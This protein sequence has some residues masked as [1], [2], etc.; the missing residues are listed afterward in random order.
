M[1]SVVFLAAA[2]LA[3]GC[4]RSPSTST[5]SPSADQEPQ[6]SAESPA[7]FKPV[8]P[9]G[10]LR[11]KEPPDQA[12]KET[13][14]I[15]L[16]IPHPLPSAIPLTSGVPF[17]RGVATS[18]SHLRLED[19][20]GREIPIQVAGLARWPDGSYKSIAITM[21]AEASAGPQV[22]TLTSGPAATRTTSPMPALAVSDDADRVTIT[23]GPMRLQI[24]K[25]PFH[26][27]EQVWTD[28]N[29]DHVFDDA[30]RLLREPA[31]IV[32]I[33]AKDGAE[34][35]SA[36]ESKPEVVVE[37][38]GPVRAVVRS[39]GWL[40]ADGGKPLTKFIVRTTAYAGRDWVEV[41]YTL[42]DPREERINAPRQGLALE[43]TGYGIRVPTTIAEGTGL[44]AGEGGQAYRGPAAGEHFLYQR[45]TLNHV[46]G[47]FESYSF[48]FEG[49]ARG[50]RADGWADL[51]NA[52]A[53]AAVVL[54][55]FWQ[56][57]PKELSVQ[58]QDLTIWLHPPRAAT[59][60]PD[61][62]PAN[63]GTRYERPTTFYA[64]REG[65]AKT[66]QLLFAFHA[67]AGDPTQ[68]RNLAAAFQAHP[69]LI[70]SAA[71]YC[72][73]GAF[74]RLLEAGAWS[75]GY[76]THLIE[77]IY[78]PSIGRKREQ[79]GTAMQYGWRDFGDRM[80][81]GWAGE[82]NG[83]K[84]PGFYNDTHVGAHIFLIQY[85][86]TLDPRWWETGET[87]TRHWM[88]L[89]VSH[90]NRIGYWKRNGR[91]VGFGPGEGHLI[92]HEMEDHHS[93][94]LHTGHAHV[95]GL[96]D[97]Y[98]LTGD[99]R[100]LEVM[101]EVGDWW[102]H[103]APVLFP[104]P[105]PTP[106]GA[107]AERD[108]GWP[109][110]TLNEIYRGTGDP[111]YLEASAQ[112]ARHVLGWWQQPSD[113]MVNHRVVGRNDWRQGT[114]WW[115]MHPHCDNCPEGFNG[116][117][118]W[119]AGALL[120]AVIRFREYNQDYGLVDDAL[121]KEMLLQ[122]M[123]YVVKYGW[124]DEKRYFVYSEAARDTD[125]GMNHLLFPLA[126]LW[127]EYQAGGLAHPEW[128]DTASQWIAIATRGY[129]DAYTVRWRG[130]TSD[131]FY[132]YETI[133]PGD[134]FSIMRELE[135]AGKLPRNQPAP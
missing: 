20:M 132:G 29:A 97:Y 106:H 84:I 104:T 91:E 25:R 102:I 101:R 74:G 38:S 31:D 36:R 37:E 52:Q 124:N 81:P 61:P 128:Y 96:P 17:P 76:D 103:A 1:I 3:A 57:F 94:N 22:F 50:A 11:A 66:Y 78:E 16:S 77:G 2:L 75:Q 9:K 15:K 113:H 67:G 32:L 108:Y 107:E 117:N 121:L 135:L 82:H 21:V 28:H 43:A 72:N 10:T 123:N 86:R 6:S 133:E 53:G 127:R 69:R 56:Q 100:A 114:G 90:G 4:Q 30:E 125:G 49:V 60:Q 7:P 51:S 130:S 27:F 87:A 54:R 33:N 98:L 63:G 41:D 129:D 24:G 89:D 115:Y 95:S 47:W 68:L 80:R 14:S 39:E 105:T 70:A 59:Q 111:K 62:P 55:N 48:A 112:I 122:T 58:D 64:P 12:P 42:V 35:S 23:T 131:G 88:D 73:T 71:W 45:G 119:M 8:A 18:L 92:K 5:A 13:V 83:V 40:H 34:Y 46:N 126:Y 134:F 65:M 118:P 109:L 116:T 99:R 120:G 44:F 19:E 110:F 93:R 85:L 26:L 79:G